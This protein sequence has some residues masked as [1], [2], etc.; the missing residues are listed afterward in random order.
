MGGCDSGEGVKLQGCFTGVL[1][2]GRVPGRSLAVDLGRVAT[3]EAQRDELS[4]A[5]RVGS[6]AGC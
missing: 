4:L 2:P 3:L 6:L 5:G 1:V